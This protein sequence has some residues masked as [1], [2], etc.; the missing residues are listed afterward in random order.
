MKHN[1]SILF[2][3]NREEEFEDTKGILRIIEEE[4]TTQWPKE[5]DK[6]T[7]NDLQNIC[8]KQNLWAH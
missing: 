2:F 3:T 7:N 8:I 4:Q 1:H 5:R 6:R